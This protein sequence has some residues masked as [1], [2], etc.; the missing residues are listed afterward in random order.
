MGKIYVVVQKGTGKYEEDPTWYSILAA[1]DMKENAKK[2][3]QEYEKTA[4]KEAYYTSYSIVTI[5][6]FLSR[7]T[8]IKHRPKQN[9]FPIGDIIKLK[10]LKK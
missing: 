6:L 3:L 4:P 9:T 8:K 1:F 7:K 2:Y 10:T 5:P